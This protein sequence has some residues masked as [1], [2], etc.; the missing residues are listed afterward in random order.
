MQ[1]FIPKFIL[2]FGTTPRAYHLKNIVSVIFILKE[3]ITN[4][5]T[6]ITNDNSDKHSITNITD[7]DCFSCKY[8]YLQ[9]I[10]D[11][12]GGIICSPSI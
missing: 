4:N 8:I 9:K 2:L 10:A 1:N 3:P 11:K 5:N 12:R 6:V 7:F